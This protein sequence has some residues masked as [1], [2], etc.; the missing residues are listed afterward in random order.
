MEPTTVTV[1]TRNVYLGGDITRPIRAAEGRT[2]GDALLALGHANHELRGIVDRT[3]FHVR[4]GLLA[5]EIASTRPDLIGLQEVAMWRSGPLEL[6]HIGQP[7]A[8]MVDY[9][10]LQ[11]LLSALQ[12]RDVGYDV[13]QVQQASDVEAPAFTGDPL[14]GPAESA[15]GRPAHRLRCDLAPD[16]VV[17]GDLRPRWRPVPAAHPAHARRWLVRVRARIRLGRRHQRFRPVP[18]RHHSPGVAECGRGAG[19]GAGA[20]QRCRA[21]I[22]FADGHRLRLQF[23]SHR[24][25]HPTGRTVA[26][27]ST[28]DLLTGLGF[29]DAWLDRAAGSG[30]GFTA[31]LGELVN[32]PSAAALG[33][34]L[35]LVLARDAGKVRIRAR[36]GTITGAETTD[37]DAAT[38]LWPS[39]HAGVVVQLELS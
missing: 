38:G 23:R 34:R 28:Y 8:T 16:L 4:A 13:V 20:G 32:D 37:R 35:D 2:G 6:D 5:K 25:R 1:M 21:W 36:G 11:L 12:D 19:A 18:V 7:N 31:T 22:C 3:D 26:R 15:A 39:D 27:S 24:R 9:D 29:R 10:Y 33:R 30:P 14:T 17:G